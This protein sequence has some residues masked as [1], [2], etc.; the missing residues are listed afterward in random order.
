MLPSAIAKKI[1]KMIVMVYASGRPLALSVLGSIRKVTTR[2]PLPLTK[3]LSW[4]AAAIDVVFPITIYRV[5]SNVGFPKKTLDRV[6]P[7][8]VRIYAKHDFQTN[9]TDWLDRFSYPYVHYYDTG[10]VREWYER[11]GLEAIQVTNLGTYGVNG[12]G[13]MGAAPK[14]APPSSGA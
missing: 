8:H 2:L 13:T 9:Y 4:L 1:G 11:A 5:L 10:E 14:A 3:A 12:V 6:T 7:E